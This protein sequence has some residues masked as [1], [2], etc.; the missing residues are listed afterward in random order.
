PLCTSALCHFPSGFRLSAHRH[1]QC[2]S[3]PILSEVDI[4]VDQPLPSDTPQPLQQP[5][6]LRR[7]QTPESPCR[8]RHWQSLPCSSPLQSPTVPVAA[9][10]SAPAHHP[11]SALVSVQIPCSRLSRQ[12]PPSRRTVPR[13]GTP[14]CT[15]AGCSATPTRPVACCTAS[16]DP[17][18]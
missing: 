18:H 17:S 14:R 4:A 1:C 15:S 12:P 7:I 16:P 2:P 8:Q 10:L 9:P 13:P 6:M 11:G 5:S 3:L